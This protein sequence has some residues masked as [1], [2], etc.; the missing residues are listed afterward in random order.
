MQR[1]QKVAS[2]QLTAAQQRETKFNKEWLSEGEIKIKRYLSTLDLE[3]LNTA[4]KERYLEILPI[5][6][7]ERYLHILCTTVVNSVLDNDMCI[8]AKSESI[9]IILEQKRYEKLQAKLL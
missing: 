1:F 4:V 9:T 5:T 7:K 3:I 8:N 2:S 6:V